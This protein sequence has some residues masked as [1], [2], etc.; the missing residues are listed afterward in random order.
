MEVVPAVAERLRVLGEGHFTGNRGN[1]TLGRLRRDALGI[2][3]EALEAVDPRLAVLRSL[4]RSD[5]T[6]EVDSRRIHVPAG[7]IH[8]LAFGKAAG[9]M[10]GAALGILPEASGL[11]VTNQRVGF[12]GSALRV[13]TASHPLP[14]GGSLRA[15]R[16]TLELVDGLGRGDLLLVLISGGGSSLLEASPIPLEDLRRAYDILLRSGLTVREVNEVRRGLSD[17]K[18]GRLAQRL[19]RRGARAVALIISDI[20]GNPIQDIASGPTAVGASRGER[21]AG[22]LH[23]AGLWDSMPTSVRRRLARIEGRGSVDK[24]RVVN[25]V[26]ADVATACRAAA[27]E[28]RRRGYP[29][30]IVSASLE[31][32]A[33]EVGP[34]FVSQAL[35]LE[36]PTTSAF[37]AGGETTVTVRGQGR[38]GRNQEFVLSAI[39]L[40]DGR[41]AVLVSFGTDGVDGNTDAAGAVADGA[42]LGRARAKGLDPIRYL[43]DNNSF[44]FFDAL[45]DLITTGP[46]G[47]N[48][49]DLQVLLLAR[50]GGVGPSGPQPLMA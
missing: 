14:D 33:R 20:P 32:E 10:A 26:V 3:A 21:A 39:E 30:K 25:V 36:R 4:R 45:G 12:P 8:L 42:T 16:E 31:G 40:L 28:A 27:A 50:G 2:L 29:A 15:G 24:R 7:K 23:R 41:E 11:V 47:T 5:T 46:T 49:A 22:I 44:E 43:D 9:A 37:V 19:Q 1:P 17:V 35:A 18:G 13:V 34:R 38:G 6:L 48:V